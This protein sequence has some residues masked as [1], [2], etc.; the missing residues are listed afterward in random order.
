[1][2]GDERFRE[3]AGKD[4][5]SPVLDLDAIA[6]AVAKKVPKAPTID[7][8][9]TALLPKA[10]ERIAEA[11][12]K[13]EP[14]KCKA[15][16]EVEHLVLVVDQSAD[17]WPRLKGEYEMAKGAYSAFKLAPPPPFS[18]QLPQLVLYRNND[19]V[20]KAVGLQEVS[21]ALS[22]IHRGGAF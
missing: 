14:C 16:A 22:V 21:Q 15:K 4:G 9:I 11:I 13:I 19:Y 12:G 2:I 8:I 3:P 18:V 20:K 5:I 1:M 10:D 7:E 6:S 17:F